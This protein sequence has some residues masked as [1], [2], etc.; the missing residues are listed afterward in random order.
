MKYKG[1]KYVKHFS[2][3]IKAKINIKTHIH[4]FIK[5]NPTRVHN[6]NTMNNIYETSAYY[7]FLQRL[8]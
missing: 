6:M 2:C 8:F 1:D 4:V 7:V 5:M 3:W